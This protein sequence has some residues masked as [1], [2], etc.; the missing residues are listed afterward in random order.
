[1]SEISEKFYGIENIKTKIYGI[2][3]TN[4]KTSVS[5]LIAQLLSIK[6]EK[7]G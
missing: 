3:G 6:K 2:T 7:C 1:M 5:N 4:G